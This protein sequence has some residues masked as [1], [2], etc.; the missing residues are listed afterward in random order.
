MGEMTTI[1]VSKK[2]RDELAKLTKYGEG[3]ND[4]LGRLLKELK[5]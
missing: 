1:K 4:A 5:K 3:L 2:N